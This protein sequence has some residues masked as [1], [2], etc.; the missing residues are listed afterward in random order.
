MFIAHPD[1]P[2]VAAALQEWTTAGLL[3]NDHVAGCETCTVASPLRYNRCRDGYHLAAERTAKAMAAQAADAKV[4][5]PGRAR[6]E[7]ERP[8]WI[9]RD[10]DA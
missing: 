10:R 6:P 9:D 3:L 8:R 1:D 2:D 5:G 7:G 4:S